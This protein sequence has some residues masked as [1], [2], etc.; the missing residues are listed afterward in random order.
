M[1]R[2]V[3]QRLAAPLD[4]WLLAFVLTLFLVSLV[5]VYSAANANADKVID[6]ARS[7]LV[8]L[9][10]MWL[11]AHLKPQTLMRLAVPLYATGVVLL[12]LVE[13]VGVK[14]NGAQRWLDLGI[15]RIQPS[16]WLK[17]AVPM[18]LAWYF[19]RH[20]SAL[21][22]RH[23]IVA[24][25]LIALPV[26]LVLHQPDL[27]TALLISAAG[28]YV[29]FLAGLSW[30]LILP[31]IVIFLATAWWVTDVS[32]CEQV[33]KPY[34]CERVQTQ[35]DPFHDPLGKGY[36]IIQGTT[37]IGSG[38]VT[39]KGWLQGTQTHLD[40]IPERTTDFIFAV[41]SEEFGLI[42]NA[43]LLILYLCVIVRGLMISQRA[44]SLFG[45]LL[46]GALTLSF[47]TYALVNMGMVS[48][49]LPVVGVPL[50][51]V[52]YGGTAVLSI[53]IGFGMLMSIQSDRKLMK[54]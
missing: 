19:H 16:E 1:I 22:F 48:G 20:E 43:L 9:S 37:A 23:F 44:S 54:S 29:L 7:M 17:T 41:Y 49:L 4:G 13:L 27:G 14:V 30:R 15:T 36:H 3:W 42:G 47:F 50:P 33:F 28:F 39:G 21:N 11:V 40:F 34:Q 2:R 26:A 46:A 5:T 52:S 53:L 24:G 51:L 32:R 18:T 25:G 45:R 8:A 6:K 12:V 38:G 35:I 31:L 10:A